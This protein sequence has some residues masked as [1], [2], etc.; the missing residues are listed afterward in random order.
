MFILILDLLDSP[1]ATSPVNLSANDI[2]LIQIINTSN[3]ENGSIISN[4]STLGGSSSPYKV[5]RQITPRERKRVLRAAPN[6]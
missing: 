1:S 3:I 4:L 2:N 6:G 5:Q